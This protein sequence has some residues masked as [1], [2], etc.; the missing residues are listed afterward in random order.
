VSGYTNRRDLPNCASNGRPAGGIALTLALCGPPHLGTIGAAAGPGGRLQPR[1]SHCN[2]HNH[3]GSAI[4]IFAPAE[5]HLVSQILLDSRPQEKP[6]AGSLAWQG[7]ARRYLGRREG[8]DLRGE[9]F[10]LWLSASTDQVAWR[11][12]P[13]GLCQVGRDRPLAGFG[14]PPSRPGGSAASDRDN[15]RV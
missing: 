14:G 2:R 4:R 15:N 6:P 7:S 11:W 1:V 13:D 3:P 8:I 10:G 5:E 9:M 12:E